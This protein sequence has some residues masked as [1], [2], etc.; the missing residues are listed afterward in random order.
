MKEYQTNK[1][2]I[3]TLISLTC[4]YGITGD[5]NRVMRDTTNPVI[6]LI[7][8]RFNVERDRYWEYIYYNVNRQH[9]GMI[10]KSG[11]DYLLGIEK[12]TRDIFDVYEEMTQREISIDTTQLLIEMPEED[13][14]KYIEALKNFYGRIDTGLTK[15]AIQS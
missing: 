9:L 15:K 14:I 5:T 1:E 2:S 8:E 12:V 6:P 10:E 4:K 3:E 7:S 11:G 13:Q